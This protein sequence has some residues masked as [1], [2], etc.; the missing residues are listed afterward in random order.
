MSKDKKSNTLQAEV[1][2]FG[3]AS[4]QPSQHMDRSKEE[5]AQLQSSLQRV[6]ESSGAH[7]VR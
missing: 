3:A 4:L 1:F 7:S 2:C 5:V 6:W